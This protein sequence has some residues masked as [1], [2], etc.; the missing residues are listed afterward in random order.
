MPSLREESGE[1]PDLPRSWVHLEGW[2]LVRGRLRLFIV[3]FG[4]VVFYVE[5]F[6]GVVVEQRRDRERWGV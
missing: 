5:L 6:E 2:R 1:A 4:I 3:F